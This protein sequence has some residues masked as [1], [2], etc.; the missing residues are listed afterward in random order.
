QSAIEQIFHCMRIDRLA[1]WEFQASANLDD[2]RLAVVLVGPALAYSADELA[3]L[4]GKEARPSRHRL[5]APSKYGVVDVALDDVRAVR[6]ELRR[7]ERV[8]VGAPAHRQR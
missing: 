1:A 4:S 5:G 8:D 3:W 2:E 7:I 6:L